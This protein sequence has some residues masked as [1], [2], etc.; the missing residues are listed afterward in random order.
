MLA[1]DSPLTFDELANFLL[2]ESSFYSPSGLHGLIAGY[3]AGGGISPEL[4]MPDFQIFLELEQLSDRDALTQF[5]QKIQ[6]SLSNEDLNFT[7]I[8]PDDEQDLSLRL[9]ALA[10]WCEGFLAGFGLNKMPQGK[11][12]DLV[13]E[14]LNDYAAISQVDIE[15]S[16]D[17]EEGE[18]DYFGILEFVRVSALNI[19]LEF[20]AKRK[21]ANSDKKQAGA[22]QYFNA[23]KL[24]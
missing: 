23:K 10:H 18:E 17:G 12:P 4:A 2:S 7:P 8:L 9:E 19:F 15:D 20:K 21:P 13:S 5:H 6:V 24:H 16:E 14:T 3:L 1:V 22:S 11:L